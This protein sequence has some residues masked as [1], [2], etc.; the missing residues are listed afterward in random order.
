[1]LKCSFCEAALACKACGQPVRPRAAETHLGIYQPDT[2]VACP[3]CHQALV[4]KTCGFA[5]GGDENGDPAG[6]P[7]HD[8]EE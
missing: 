8:A 6:R 1:M 2:A 5:Y 7:A 3:A 4:C